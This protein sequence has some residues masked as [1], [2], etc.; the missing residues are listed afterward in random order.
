VALTVA[1]VALS[2]MLTGVLS[3]RLGHA[4]WLRPV[5]RNV[6]GGA[7]AMA[8]TYGVGTLAGTLL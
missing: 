1:T 3:A 7:L 2:L 6:L 4:H 5:L 8:M